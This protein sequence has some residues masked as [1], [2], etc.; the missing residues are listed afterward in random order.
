MHYRRNHPV[1]RLGAAALR[2]LA[3]SIWFMP[4]QLGASNVGEVQGLARQCRSGKQRACGEL[5][6]IAAKDSDAGVRSAA[7]AGLTVSS[8]LDPGR[9][10]LLERIA[11]QDKDARVRGAAQARLTDLIL[12]DRLH[13]KDAVAALNPLT[14][15]AL[16]ARIAT[17]S[18]VGFIPNL[19]GAAVEKLTDQSLLFR[20]ASNGLK[21][22]ARDAALRKLD[23]TFLARIALNP[24]ESHWGDRSFAASR[25][26]DQLVLARLALE[27]DSDT[28]NWQTRLEVIGRLEN[29]DALEAVARAMEEDGTPWP[30]QV[31]LAVAERLRNEGILE[32]IAREDPTCPARA[33]AA[34]RL[35]S[36]AALQRLADDRR[37]DIDGCSRAIARLKLAILEPLIAARIPTLR[38]QLWASNIEQNYS[39]PGSA[40]L[41][42]GES[43]AADLYVGNTRVCQET[44]VTDF[45][46]SIAYGTLPLIQAKVDIKPLL[47]KLLHLPMF[48]R[49]DLVEISTSAA[50]ADVRSAA[51]ANI[52][53]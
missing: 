38:L 2:G 6:R 34:S 13:E 27:K 19:G 47:T 45:P 40:G 53:Q 9:R 15:Q 32:T 26:S 16:L 11:A 43:I 42:V 29:Q 46:G 36:K 7:V 12:S 14:D 3:I 20:V 52:K 51:L 21:G 31:R 48:T 1:A 50:L 39:R 22:P 17:K 44:W 30:W 18:S 5:A 23:Q 28:W 10:S 49:Q 8:L 37:W 25:L 33:T 24:N 35:A 41:A 4:G